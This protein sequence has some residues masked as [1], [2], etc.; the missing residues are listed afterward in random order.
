MPSRPAAVG[1]A[2]TNGHHAPKLFFVWV[3]FPVD[4]LMLPQFFLVGPGAVTP[5]ALQVS[6]YFIEGDLS[7]HHWAPG[8][9]KP[10][11]NVDVRRGVPV[12]AEPERAQN[13]NTPARARHLRLPLLRLA[14]PGCSRAGDDHCEVRV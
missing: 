8:H 3:C 9:L 13:G 12:G 5:T 4:R 7:I 6:A 10:G 1:P 11:L 2:G 14:A